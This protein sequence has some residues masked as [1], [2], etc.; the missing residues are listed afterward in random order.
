MTSKKYLTLEEAAQQLGL[1]TDEVIRLRE[2]GELRGYADRGTWKFKADDILE[3]KRR[4]QPDSSPEVQ[5]LPE[6]DS[7]LDLDLSG[8]QSDSDVRLVTTPDKP[9]KGLTGSSTDLPTFS[10][11]TSDSD[12]RLVEPPSQRP[13]SD[14][15]VKLVASGSDPSAPIPLADS[16]SDVR[17]AGRPTAGMADSDSDVKLV[18]TQRGKTGLGTS[19]SIL[20]GGS[21]SV[22]DI[23][24]EG[25]TLASDSGISLA[26][27]SGIQLAPAEDSGISLTSQTEIPLALGGAKSASSSPVDDLDFTAP[28]LL[29]EPSAIKTDPEVPLLADDDDLESIPL[30]VASHVGRDTEAE[31]NILMFDDDESPTQTQ[32]ILEDYDE[33][34]ET[35]AVLDDEAEVIEVA[36]EEEEF[37]YGEGIEEESIFDTGMSAAEI[38]VPGARGWQIEREWDASA[39]SLA[40]V[41]T[42]M[43]AL[44]VWM[45]AD[46]LQAITAMASGGSYPGLVGILSTLYR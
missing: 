9:Q 11:A 4:L 22:L 7:A 18:E 30:S 42:L 25:I 16:D 23:D 31:T 15:D 32:A 24:D 10:G 26:E 34:G 33:G 12:V 41:S 40:A 6:G 3:Y 46:L 36:Q 2:K 28:M 5:L 35:A 19:D 43:L 8:L 27:D 20:M 21:D 14:S 37:D 13:G 38:S 29:D 45:S 44:T 1:R 17:L 39:V